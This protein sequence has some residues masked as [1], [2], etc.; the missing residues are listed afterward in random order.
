MLSRTDSNAGNQEFFRVKN[1]LGP[2]I[3]KKVGMEVLSGRVIEA[4]KVGSESWESRN[5]ESEIQPKDW[6]KPKVV[7]G[8]CF[9]VLN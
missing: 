3:R 7:E 6:Y 2:G 8:P 9:N 5:F 4:G 1:D